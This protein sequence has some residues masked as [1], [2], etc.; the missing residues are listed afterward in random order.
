MKTHPAADIESVSGVEI[1]TKG[2]ETENDYELRTR[3]SEAKEGLGSCNEI[4]IKSALLRIPTVTHAGVIVNETD[5]TDS[6]GRPARSF[7]CYVSGGNNYHEQIAE[8]IFEKKPIG[9]K[10]HGKISQ[11]I[12]DI[13]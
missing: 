7:E 1:I 11:E 13:P 6:D 4:A 5:T 2:Q 8:T 9:I 3:F 12:T 10:T